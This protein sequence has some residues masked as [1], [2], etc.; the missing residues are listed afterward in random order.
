M[1][2]P[3]V[4][5]LSIFTDSMLTDS[6]KWLVGK[7]TDNPEFKKF[8][9]KH[10]LL[11]TNN[12]FF[13][14]YAEAYHALFHDE[15][16][17]VL[18]AFF[19]E[20]S[21]V[22]AI[23]DFKWS[24][25]RQVDFE[26]R[27]AEIGSHLTVDAQLAGTG[28]TLQSEL[29]AFLRYFN[30]TVH[31]GRSAAEVE[32]HAMLTEIKDGVDNLKTQ[33]ADPNAVWRD[34]YPNVNPYPKPRFFRDSR[35]E[36]LAAVRTQL[37]GDRCLVLV[38]GTGGIGKTAVAAAF[39][40]DHAADFDCIV[41]MH[42]ENRI[43]EAFLRSPLYGRLFPPG[44]FAPGTPEDTIFEAMLARFASAPEGRKLLVLDNAN[45]GKDLIGNERLLRNLHGWAVLVTSRA[46]DT[47]LPRRRIGTLPPER[48]FALFC[49]HFPPAVEQAE[50]LER[51]LVAIGY[52][53][54]LVECLAK[55]LANRL[56]K[57]KAAD[58]QALCDNLGEN[59]AL[60]LPKAGP[61]KV[62][63]HNHPPAA[64]DALLD[65]LFTLEALDEPAQRLLQQLA[66]LPAEPQPLSLLYSL[67]GLEDETEDSA[68]F[69]AL[70]EALAHSG[71]LEFYPGE[72]YRLHPVPGAVVRRRLH[73]TYAACAGLLTRLTNLLGDETVHLDRRLELCDA[74]RSVAGY[75]A[76]EV[77]FGVGSLHVYLADTEFDAGNF[78]D[79]ERLL[80][81]AVRIFEAAGDFKNQSAVFVRLGCFFESCGHFD[82]ALEF[83]KKSHALNAQ[84]FQA[85]PEDEW[86]KHSL[87]ISYGKL[88]DLWQQRG[89]F[90]RALD[91]FEKRSQLGE[92]LYASNPR[93]E[94]LK[95]GLANSYVKLGELWQQRGDFDRALDY[96][97]KETDLF[98]ELY[99]ANPQN[100]QLLDGLA[101]S[102]FKLGDLY[103]AMEK[104]RQARPYFQKFQ[105]YCAELWET[106]K[107][108]KYQEWLEI[109][110]ARLE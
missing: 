7:L 12:D 37:A 97:E 27:M 56:A 22:Q 2:N 32:D 40:A 44:A 50:L 75:L 93:N 60:Q 107:M 21:V 33:Q 11:E 3:L 6:A 91:Y 36:E 49:D 100:I 98:E 62:G 86:A 92:E 30:I 70:L 39:C 71:W 80:R 25:L 72:G 9:A 67:F 18:K 41:W 46:D 103:T 51:L 110:A 96:F 13:D 102:C 42:C 68:A 74:A 54:L 61:V 90:D 20:I 82:S 109:V 59:G 38:N 52:H 23:E 99:A 45:N 81:E 79:T 8:K 69:D 53:T 108:P 26:K 76:V 73:P 28:Y 78:S 106:T 65:A 64:P 35:T 63:W 48:A 19:N 84:F 57:G 29:A 31:A 24:R 85:E 1:P 14:R 17:Q 95:H 101:V 43:R 94:S 83:F 58:L 66:L 88:G 77:N 4:N 10:G 47:G 89:D 55:H 87:A 34:K 105:E 16:P 15:K 104:T 5:I